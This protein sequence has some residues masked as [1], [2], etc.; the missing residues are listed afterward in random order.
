MKTSTRHRGSVSSRFAHLQRAETSNS[1]SRLRSNSNLST[2]EEAYD[3]SIVHE[4]EPRATT[5]M[6]PPVMVSA[7]DLSTGLLTKKRVVESN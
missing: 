3:N 5:A 2:G 7:S 1:G 6:L 4:V